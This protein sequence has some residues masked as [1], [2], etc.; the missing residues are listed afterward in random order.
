MQEEMEALLENQTWELVELPKGLKASG[1]KWVCKIK[2]DGND[3]VERYCARLMVKRYA[4]KEGIN[5]KE[6]FYPV[7]RLT[8][9]R[10]VLAMCVAFDLHVEQLDLKTTFLHGELQEKI[11]MLQSEGF[12]E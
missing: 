12:E 9:I 2:Q 8:T 4:K 11:Y 3:Q 6:I 1:N 10:A 5:F 7:V